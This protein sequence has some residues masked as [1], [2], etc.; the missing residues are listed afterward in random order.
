M[1]WTCACTATN[2][3]GAQFCNHCG[4]PFAPVS[5]PP[6]MPPGPGRPAPAFTGLGWKIGAIAGV[7][8]AGA[9]VGTLVATMGAGS[10]QPAAQTSAGAIASTKSAF[11]Q[12]FDASFQRSCRQSAMR[13]GRVSQATADR[14]C[15][16]ALS[17]LHDT[18]SMT[19]VVDKCKQY[20][21]R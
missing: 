21:I 11:Q 17:V 3:D 20:A 7:L 13:S 14:Y 5:S 8:V 9:I 10:T 1:P 15:E 6:P 2:G 19:K 12:S 16:C 4:R 18:H